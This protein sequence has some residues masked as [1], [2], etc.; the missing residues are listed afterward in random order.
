MRWLGQQQ[1]TT[2][3]QWFSNEALFRLVVD[4]VLERIRWSLLQRYLSILLSGNKLVIVIILFPPIYGNAERGI[5]GMV[6]SVMG[7]EDREWE[8]GENFKPTWS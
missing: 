2:S 5:G 7:V 8:V 3:Q 1:D 4:A 6:L